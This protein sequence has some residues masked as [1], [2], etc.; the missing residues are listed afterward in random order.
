MYSFQGLKRTHCQMDHHSKN[1]G[2]IYYSL[3]LAVSLVYGV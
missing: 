3:H 1:M 2:R